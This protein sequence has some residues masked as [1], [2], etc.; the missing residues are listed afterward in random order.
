[1][2][3]EEFWDTLPHCCGYPNCDGDLETTAHSEGCPLHNRKEISE[4]EFA[5]LYAAEVN[6]ELA[7]ALNDERT[8]LFSFLE[9]MSTLESLCLS[10]YR[11]SDAQFKGFYLRRACDLRQIIDQLIKHLDVDILAKAGAD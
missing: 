10:D 9:Q 2:T 11:H 1:M 7:E 4:M 8:K 5:S 6:K 3:A